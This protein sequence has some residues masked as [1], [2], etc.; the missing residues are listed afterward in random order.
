MPLHHTPPSPT[1][2][3]EQARRE[4]LLQLRAG[5]ITQLAA[6]DTLLGLPRTVPPK[7]EREQPLDRARRDV[8]K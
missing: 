5:L 4:A 3:T 8:L 1:E 6:L 7:R 2:L